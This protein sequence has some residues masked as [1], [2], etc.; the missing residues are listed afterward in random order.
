MKQHKMQCLQTWKK[1]LTYRDDLDEV[2]SVDGHDLHLRSCIAIERT[3]YTLDITDDYAA[4]INY[5]D[6]IFEEDPEIWD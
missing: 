3:E 1:M 6:N 5:S 2:I 4:L